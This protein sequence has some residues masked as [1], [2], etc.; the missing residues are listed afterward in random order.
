MTFSC[1]YYFGPSK[2]IVIIIGP[3]IKAFV[4]SGA[5]FLFGG[6][7]KMFSAIINFYPC[8][9]SFQGF[10]T[11]FLLMKTVFSIKS[12]VELINLQRLS[13]PRQR[14]QQWADNGALARLS[15]TGTVKITQV[16][17]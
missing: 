16:A 4:S 10:W 13:G 17:K 12:K 8:C 14:M 2:M 7:I 6:W 11:T 3:I 15:I 5:L 9:P 1:C